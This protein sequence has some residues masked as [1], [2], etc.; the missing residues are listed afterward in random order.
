M[1]DDDI[2]I[3]S[4]LLLGISSTNKIINS[5]SIN[6]LQELYKK[7]YDLFLYCILNIIEK[8]TNSSDKNKILLRN[9][10]L[11][12]CRKVIEITEYEEW[13]KMD[14]YFKEKIKIKILFLLN[15]EIFSYS[16]FKLFDIIIELFSKI[17]ENEEIWP[18]L[19]DTTLSIF[20]YDPHEGDKNSPQ[21]I[22]LLYIIK[23]GI[24]FL[25]KKI[26]DFLDNLIQYLKLIFISSNI[27][28][29][30]KILSGQLISEII[31]LS[32]SSELDKIKIL[33]KNI[34][35]LLEQCYYENQSNNM[36]EKNIKSVLQI[37][38]DIESV[39]SELLK[40]YFNE[41]F[42]LSKKIISNSNFEDQKIKEMGFELLISIM[43]DIPSIVEESSNSY[44]IIYSIFNLMLNYSLNFDK[45]LDM[46]SFDFI[47]E[48]DYDSEQYF[49][50][51]EINYT[52]L[53]SERLFESIESSFYQKAF[54]TFVTNYFNKSWKNQ[55]II[56]ILVISYSKYNEDINFFKQIFESIPDLL[57]SSQSKIRFTSLYCFKNFLMKYKSDFLE[58]YLEDIFPLFINLLNNEKN[59]EC[60]YE[61]L[62]CLKY[63]MR[64]SNH[65]KLYKYI[66]TLVTLLMN[67][68]IEQN[69]SFIIRKLILINL[70]EINK[71]RDDKEINLS[72][73]KID[74]NA[75]MKYF[76]N[77]FDKKI[78]LQLYPILLEVIVFFGQYDEKFISKIS[79][80]ILNYIIKLFKLIEINNKQIFIINQFAKVFRKIFPILIKSKLDNKYINE[81]IQ[82][83]ISLIEKEKNIYSS[84]LKEIKQEKNSLINENDYIIKNNPQ[85]IYNFENEELSS[86]LSILLS[87]LN[88][89]DKITIN[90][91]LNII[92]K[93]IL[94]LIEFPL[95]KNSNKYIAILLAKIIYFSVN[96]NEKSLAYINILL[97]M[98]DKEIEIKNVKLYLEKL[99]E[100][101]EMNESEFLNQNQ[102]DYLFDK[103]YKYI[104]NLKIKTKQLIEKEK[105]REKNNNYLKEKI[106]D[107]KYDY[108]SS[109]EEIEN[110]EDI[111]YEIIDIFGILLKTHKGNC[112]YIKE[113]IIKNII[114]TFI[115]S[116]NILDIKLALNLCD[117]LI[118]HLG[119]EQ[120]LENIWDYFYDILR[121]FIIN[122]DN[123]IIQI[124]SYGI[125]IFARNTANN[126]SKYS[127]GLIESL[128]QS[129][130]YSLKL[131]QESNKKNEDLFLAL[132][133]IIAAIGKIIYYH[134]DDQIVNENWNELVTNW[135]M[136]LPIKFDES[137]W[138]D[139]HEWMVNLFI[140]KKELIPLNCYSHYFQSLAEIY[141]TKY[142]NEMVDKNIENIF[143][144]YVKKDEQLLNILSVIYEN[145][146]L[147][148]KNKLNFLA[149][150]N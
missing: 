31:S 45:N 13:E 81:L 109:N 127:N 20:N 98:I 72:L 53:L 129:L 128:C 122:E 30:A 119:Q 57:I 147:D 39:E 91:L 100:I 50:E 32:I 107:E 10:S 41:I 113:Q 24:N 104:N 101:I 99:K 5:N 36:D 140:N 12:I 133:N 46:N 14:D 21:I 111:Q 64:Y 102:I 146:S 8:T 84:K 42:E 35:N 23:G 76:F 51:E 73:N 28:I 126:F 144:N 85:E 95:D 55:Y 142:S 37:L 118:L 67:I 9:T 82:I 59:F 93:E 117:D 106:N 135:M 11:V 150:L 141:K 86:V 69:S 54:Q 110:Y 3:I 83:L 120:F 15:N 68:F 148:I 62:F 79:T 103:L 71:K 52:S 138:I 2:Q 63:I 49:I 80:D 33:I 27:D 29:K 108:N 124:S 65:S 130:S 75:L 26:S 87:I 60:K 25:Y 58:K 56:L 4:G 121:K 77:L 115:N 116:K 134:F 139:Q 137:E 7:K 114:P 34:L 70:L 22:A 17:F 44:E 145:S 78:D 132:D 143:V 74:I 96:K 90:P 16:N 94:T 112:N 40:I 123:S 88:S 131:K 89:I 66:E 136:N 47:K 38:I 48:I 92:E 19:L 18:E 105:V 149:Q 97:N 1:S 6:Q 125:G 61:S 43:E